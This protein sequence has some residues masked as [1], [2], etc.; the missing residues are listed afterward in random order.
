MDLGSIRGERMLEGIVFSFVSMAFG[1]FAGFMI[2]RRDAKGQFKHHEAEA[3]AK[4]NAIVYEAEKILQ[5]AKISIKE[6]EVEL[7][8]KMQE[9]DFRHREGRK[10]DLMA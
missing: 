9:E 4:A 8:K 1:S 7:E 6:K 2:A 3:K 10:T 5:E